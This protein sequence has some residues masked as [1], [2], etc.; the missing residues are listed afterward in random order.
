MCLQLVM[1]LG[2]VVGAS[3]SLLAQRVAEVAA[4]GVLPFTAGGFIYLGTVTVLPEL[5]R[6]PSPLQSL[7]QL[8]GLL[9]GMAMMVAIGQY[10]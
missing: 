8:L 6:D 2:A 7:L 3:C 4:S 9:G 1:A 10:E 5:L